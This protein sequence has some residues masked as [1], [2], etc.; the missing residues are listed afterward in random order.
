MAQ[1]EINNCS[2]MDMEMGKESVFD[3]WDYKGRPADRSKT[4]GW[5][6]AAMILGLFFFSLL[7]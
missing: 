6:S 2:N 3:A 4:G 1:P 7:I 5:K